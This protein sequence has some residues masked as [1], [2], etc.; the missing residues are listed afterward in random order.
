MKPPL[1]NFLLQACDEGTAS[2]WMS[3]HL[4]QL[5]GPAGSISSDGCSNNSGWLDA[6]SCCLLAC[7]CSLLQQLGQRVMQGCS[8]PLLGEHLSQLWLTAQ[9]VGAVEA[10]RFGCGAQ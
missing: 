7:Q 3:Q 2:S 6:G 1:H 9:Q 10:V 4:L 5:P 8:Q